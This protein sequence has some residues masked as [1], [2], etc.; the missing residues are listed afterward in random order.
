MRVAVTQPLTK[1]GQEFFGV[2][3]LLAEDAD[4]SQGHRP[5][6]GDIFY[7]EEKGG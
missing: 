1:R 2:R 7:D 3:G 6:L 5:H 4:D